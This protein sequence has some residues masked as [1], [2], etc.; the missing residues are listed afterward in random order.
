[1]VN[2]ARQ[3]AAFE[4]RIIHDLQQYGYDC[5]RSAASKGAVDIVAIPGPPREEDWKLWGRQ[6]VLF[7]QAK[8]SKPLISPAE[9]LAVQNLALRAGA[10]PLVS[11]WAKDATT[12]LMRVHYRQLTG[13]GPDEWAHWAPGED[14]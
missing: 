2:T 4:R 5:I 14:N 1:M 9:R 12:G 11:W 3:G 6:S 8:L 10:L 7:I 13:P